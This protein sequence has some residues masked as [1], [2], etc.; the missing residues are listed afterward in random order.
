MVIMNAI[1]LRNGRTRIFVVALV[2]VALL[3]S[4]L[5][6]NVGTAYA[7]GWEKVF[8]FKSGK[9]TYVGALSYKGTFEKGKKVRGI[10]GVK[11]ADSK[12]TVPGKVKGLKVKVVRLYKMNF[13]WDNVNLKTKTSNLKSIN[14]KN[15]T[16]MTHFYVSGSKITK[17]DISKNKKL[18]SLSLYNNKQ[19]TSVNLSKNTKLTR[20]SILGAKKLKSIDFSHNKKLKD[21]ILDK[22]IK[23]TGLSNSK[24][25]KINWDGNS[26]AYSA[27]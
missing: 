3:A 23:V 24:Y 7:D 1:N 2:G 5:F 14:L 9:D 26:V 16:E 4:M 21:I 20:V 27:I 12:I 22:G 15:V 10:L 13:N 18:T 6:I 11:S 8:K 25:K 19:L 17:L